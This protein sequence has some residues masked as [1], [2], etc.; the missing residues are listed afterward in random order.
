MKVAIT[1]LGHEVNLF[2][3]FYWTPKRRNAIL[4]RIRSIFNQFLVISDWKFNWKLLITVKAI[5]INQ[6]RPPQMYLL[7]IHSLNSKITK[8]YIK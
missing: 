7:V 6:K 3:T 5:V 1:P 4:I 8:I 2:G